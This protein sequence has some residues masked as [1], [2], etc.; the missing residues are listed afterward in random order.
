[1][2]SI[3][4]RAA[5]AALFGFSALTIPTVGSREVAATPPVAA[6]PNFS[7]PSLSPDRREIA[8]VSGGDIWT[9]PTSGGEARLL[10]SHAAYDSRPL[11]SPDGSRLA[12]QSTRTGNGDIYVLTLASGALARLTYDDAPEQLDAWSRDGKWLYFSSG[13]KDVNGMND[14]FRV[15]IDGGTPMAVS[16]DKFTQEY[17]SAPS[18]SDPNTIAFTGTGRTNSDW[19]RKGHSHIDESQIWLAH[20]GGATPTYEAVTKDAAKDAWPMW[21]ADGK[22]LYYVSDKSG[23]ENVWSK[24]ATTGGADHELTS[25]NNGRLVWPTISYDGK[26][27]AFERDFG[28]W[29]LDVAS[30]KAT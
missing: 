10:I 25:F 26:T 21:S 23:A 19:W 27:I 20:F 8:F 28:V 3:S 17:W 14:I 2:L 5:S 30:G 12:F 1:M 29:T 22:T 9:V 16:A 11:Y 7:E 18:P 6:K 4:S 15:A 13:S 24:A